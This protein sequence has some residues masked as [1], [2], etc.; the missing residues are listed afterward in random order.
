MIEIEQLLPRDWALNSLGYVGILN[1]F[2]TIFEFGKLE[3]EFE[4]CHQNIF[5]EFVEVKSWIQNFV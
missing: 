3:T 5:M 1:S 2:V 4:N